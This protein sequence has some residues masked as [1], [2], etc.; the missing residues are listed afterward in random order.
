MYSKQHFSVCVLR[1]L[2]IFT[3]TAGA[4]IA[5]AQSK[6]A[7]QDTEKGQAIAT[8]VCAACH[9]ADGNSPAAIN[10]KLA[11]QF[12]EYLGKQLENFKANVARKN[13]VMMGMSAN[14]SAD[15]IKSVAAFYAA[16]KPKDGSAKNADSA[17]LGRK[18]FRGGDVGKG[19]AACASCHGAT[20]AG[21]PSQYP[22]LAGQ[23]AE[24][25]EAQLRAFRAGERS[26]DA[27][28]MMRG[29]AEKM[30]DAEIKAVAD[31][32]AGLR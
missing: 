19:L 24:Y 14:L 21:M 12:P 11:G 7:K 30:S 9:G 25:T 16:Q 29:V 28:R 32:I 17:A 5:L 15:D 3:L 8:K 4:S 22:R 23:H 27:N 18:V 26:N 1:A 31:Y 13:P 2:T 20:G 10:P 6:A